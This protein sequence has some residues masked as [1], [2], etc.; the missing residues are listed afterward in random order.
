MVRYSFAVLMIGLMLCG[1]ADA[2]QLQDLAA[3]AEAEAT[4]GKHVAAIETLR[5]AMLVLWD[6]SPLT[7]RRAL[8]VQE[9]A[10]GFGIYNERPSNVFKQGE[11]IL[12]Y[13][14]PVGFKWSKIQQFHRSEIMA[15]FELRQPD[16][17]VLAKRENFGQF[18]F[19][20][21]V[22]NTEYM[23]NLNFAF[24]GLPAGK[25]VLGTTFRD[26]LGKQSVSFDL[27]FEV[28]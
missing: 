8:F 27:P 16:G 4:A 11:K 1:R 17:K 28:E 12:V 10:Q 5:A 9:R 2:G 22:R 7:I 24:T 15:D 14:E 6:R 20:S 13:A 26:I 25:Y 21:R 19:T 3:R 18:K 23:A